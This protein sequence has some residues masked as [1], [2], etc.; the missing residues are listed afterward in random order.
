MEQLA[1]LGADDPDIAAIVGIKLK[2]LRR[3]CGELLVRARAQRRA[4][5]RKI[6]WRLAM[7]DNIPILTWLAKT[8]LEPGSP[9]GIDPAA[10]ESKRS[11]ST[12]DSQAFETAFN[13]LVAGGPAEKATENPQQSCNSVD[14][15]GSSQIVNASQPTSDVLASTSTRSTPAASS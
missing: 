6:I 12:F 11:G 5:I 8:E 13:E 7:A 4:R 1:Q 3:Q 2:V 14:K 15:A 9:E 10:Q